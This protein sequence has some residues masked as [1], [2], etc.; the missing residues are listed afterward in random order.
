MDMV[1]DWRKIAISHLKEGPV[2]VSELF[3]IYGTGSSVPLKIAL[4]QLVSDGLVSLSGVVYRL[5]HGLID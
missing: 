3:R 1:V 5:N 2:I 4:N